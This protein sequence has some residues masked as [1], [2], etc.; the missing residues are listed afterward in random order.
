MTKVTFITIDESHQGQ[1]I[2]NFLVTILK[3]VPKSRI[4]RSL[5]QGEVRVNK[6]RAKP[7]YRLQ[8]DDVLRIPPLRIT[9]APVTPTQPA[10]WQTRLIADNILYEDEQI[11]IV[12]KPAGIAVHGGSGIH[13]GVIE[14]LRRLRPQAKFLELAH[15]LDRDTSGCLLIAKKRSAL[16]QLHQLLRDHQVE[17]VYLTLVKGYWREGKRKVDVPLMKNQ[18]LSGERIVK[19]N[20]EGKSSLTLFEP[21]ERWRHAAWVKVNLQTGRTHQIRVHAAYIKHP[22]AGDE[23]YGDAEFN[24][25]MRQAGLKRLFLHAASISFRWPATGEL[26]AVCACL[27]DDLRQCLRK[28]GE[29]V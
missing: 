1:R 25:L 19:V 8:I 16:T 18:L 29:S 22:I 17:K 27:P 23:K 10:D 7:E 3:G 26:I 12:N 21:I 15:R 20:P 6:H 4:Y 9:S 13:F 5:R 11:I 28:M 14:T 2:D 24:K